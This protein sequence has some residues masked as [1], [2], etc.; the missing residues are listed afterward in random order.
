MSIG[1][2]KMKKGRGT[3]FTYIFIL[4]FL[5][6]RVNE[7]CDLE[8]VTAAFQAFENPELCFVK[9]KKVLGVAVEYSAILS[10]RRI[11]AALKGPSVFLA[12][13]GAGSKKTVEQRISTKFYSR[14]TSLRTTADVF[15]KFQN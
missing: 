7:L 1:T 6:A 2:L 10:L 9:I 11:S 8:N 12:G 4:S 3:E 13:H 5:I 15:P 14:T